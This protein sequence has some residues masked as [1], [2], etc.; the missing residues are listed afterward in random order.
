MCLSDTIRR[1]VT[2]CL[3]DCLSLCL[4]VCLLCQDISRLVSDAE[5]KERMNLHQ[6]LQEE[7]RWYSGFVAGFSKPLVSVLSV[8]VCE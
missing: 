5:E 1:S 6:I 4:S 2:L 3:S 8:S 7:R